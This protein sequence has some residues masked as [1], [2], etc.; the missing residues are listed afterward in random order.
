MPA[1]DGDIVVLRGGRG[2]FTVETVVSPTARQR[3]LSGRAFM[4]KGRGMFFVFPNEAVHEM[5]MKEMLFP[6]DVVW[7]DSQLRVVNINW[8][9]RPCRSGTACYTYSSGAP[10]RYAIEL[11]EG[12]A[13]ALGLYA[14][15][16]VEVV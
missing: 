15:F 13:V 7:L 3:G 1:K 8:D 14:G 6:L 4:E 11:N 5:W 9:C 2:T 12:D 10:A 16:L